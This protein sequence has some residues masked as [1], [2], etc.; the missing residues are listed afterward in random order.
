M[1][2][3]NNAGLCNF[4][5]DLCLD[6]QDV[7]DSH[8]ALN[9]PDDGVSVPAIFEGAKPKKNTNFDAK[10]KEAALDLQAKLSEACDQL[11]KQ[12]LVRNGYGNGRDCRLRI[13]SEHR[14]SVKPTAGSGNAFNAIIQTILT[15]EGALQTQAFVRS[16]AQ[17]MCPTVPVTKNWNQPLPSWAI[18][19]VMTKVAGF[20]SPFDT[21]KL[22]KG[23]TLNDLHAASKIAVQKFQ[24]RAKTF[25]PEVLL[26]DT[27]LIVNGVPFAISRNKSGGKEY[28]C[29][30]VSTSKL[31]EALAKR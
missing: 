21:I 18:N 19:K 12:W 8:R 11:T 23:A 20:G 31:Q 29:V 9:E 1:N 17:E 2:Q 27:H 15:R 25:T 3:S 14:V 10:W 30:R 5:D 28:S 13:R 6:I 4:P 7:S 24:G 26:S 16:R 22:K